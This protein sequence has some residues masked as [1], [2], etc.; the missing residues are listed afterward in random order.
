MGF[1]VNL[2]S[3]YAPI[4]EEVWMPVTQKMEFSGS[5]F[6]LAGTYTYLASVS[7]YDII[8][9]SDLD[10]SVILIDEKIAPVPEEITTIKEGSV[11]EGVKEVFTEDKEVSRKQFRKLMKEYEKQEREELEEP[12]VVSDYYYKVDTTAAK[13]DSLYWAKVRPVPLTLKERQSYVKEDSTYFA[14][15]EQAEADSSRL[16]NGQRFKFT[17][18]LTGGYY[19]L[20]ERLRVWL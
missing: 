1:R 6:G 10:A 4:E 5:V 20:G 9:N 3:I 7:N 19:K 8:P 14:E 13:K 17:D 16:R 2:N 15:K 11:E 12:D 18:M